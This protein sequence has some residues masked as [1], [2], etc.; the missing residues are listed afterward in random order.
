MQRQ[1][2][3]QRG[4]IV[5]AEGANQPRGE[6]SHNSSELCQVRELYDNAVSCVL[7]AFHGSFGQLIL[8]KII[9]IVVTRM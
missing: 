7:C 5:Q 4:R 8:R 9:E 6:K 3:T 2:I 1:Y